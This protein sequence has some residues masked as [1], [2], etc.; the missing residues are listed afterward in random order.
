MANAAAP[1]LVTGFEPFDGAAINPSWEVARALQGRSIGDA[2][3]VAASLPVAFDQA[4][5]R[6][7]ALL[8]QHRPQMVVSLGLA[9]GRAAISVERVAINIMDARIADN[10]GAQPVDEPVQAGAPAA[11]FSSLPIKA[12]RRAIEDGGLPAEISQTAGTYVCNQVMFAALHALEAATPAVR[13][14]F[15]HIPWSTGLGEP[16]LDQNA[17]VEAIYQALVVALGT[18]IDVPDI[19]GATH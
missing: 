5:A 12:M 6:L 10:L 3:I 11:Y 17:M 18:P 8:A 19:G 14:G 15:I 13:S 4:P 7:Q 1:V 16:S 9:A 2:A